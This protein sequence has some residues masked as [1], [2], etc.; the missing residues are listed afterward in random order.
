MC[1]W[2]C[3]CRRERER[4]LKRDK[5]T[6]TSWLHRSVL[7]YNFPTY[8]FLLP[9]L[10]GWFTDDNALLSFLSLSSLASD[11][12]YQKKPIYKASVESLP[13]TCGDKQPLVWLHMQVEGGGGGGRRWSKR[14]ARWSGWPEN[15]GWQSGDTYRGR[16]LQVSRASQGGKEARRD[17]WRL[18]K[19]ERRW[20]WKNTTTKNLRE[21]DALEPQRLLCLCLSAEVMHLG[22]K[23]GQFILHWGKWWAAFFAEWWGIRLVKSCKESI[24][25]SLFS[26]ANIIAQLCIMNEPFGWWNRVLFCWFVSLSTSFSK[27]RN[28]FC[29]KVI[30]IF[31]LWQ[32]SGTLRSPILLTVHW[33]SFILKKYY[34]LPPVWAIDFVPF[35]RDKRGCRLLTTRWKHIF[36]IQGHL[37]LA[38]V[39]T[40]LLWT[41][42]L[43]S[44]C[45]ASSAGCC[46][47]QSACRHRPILSQFSWPTNA[48]SKNSHNTV[49]IVVKSGNVHPLE[50]EAELA[51]GSSTSTWTWCSQFPCPLPP[52]VTIIDYN[53]FFLIFSSA[54]L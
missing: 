8:S 34:S 31:L 36:S 49:R 13:S 48:W 17:I 2:A 30:I 21:N 29:A 52:R 14:Q 23:G 19:G 12:Y 9:I 15:E 43:Y 5:W 38:S 37:K 39:C 11:D 45:C 26:V 42:D 47:S 16:R 22:H 44:K 53:F 24:C 20:V 54:A 41:Y 27:A 51:S 10:G 1:I 18:G 33:I 46:F 4:E 7:V 28:G 50:E 32:L 40:P 6:F 25:N 35:Y 3:V